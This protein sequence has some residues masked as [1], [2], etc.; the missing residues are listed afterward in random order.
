MESF[1]FGFFDPGAAPGQPPQ[2]RL[3]FA[4]A[5]QGVS[6]EEVGQQDGAPP[7]QEAQL[8]RVALDGGI[9]LLKGSV[10]SQEAAQLLEEPELQASDLVPAKYEGGFKLWEGALDLANYLIAR[11]QL[12]PGLLAQAVPDGSLRGK[13]V[14]ELGCGH[15]LPGILCQMAGA[16]V[17]YQ[18]YNRQ[19][20][21]SLTM[22]NLAAN[23]AQLPRG[24]FRERPRFFAGDWGGVGQMLASSGLG[25]HYDLVLT[26]ETI[27]SAESQR[28]LLDAIKQVLQPPHGVVLVA[29]KSFYFGVGGGT[30]AFAELVKADGVLEC[31]QVW[32]V[33]DGQSN[34]REI[35]QLAFPEAIAPYFL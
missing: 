22:P 33:E 15:G 23:M 3:A 32:K 30:A 9:T 31:K 21:T 5:S 4:D 8:Q 26:A 11:H 18:D 27:Y 6:A 7:W 17:H 12:T 1:A 24:V 35:L 14:L 10:S 2:Q 29:A 13:K 25:G 20:I 16:A 28:R 34:K 19:V